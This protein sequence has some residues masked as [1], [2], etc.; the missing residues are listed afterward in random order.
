M[1]PQ[2]TFRRLP[3]FLSHSHTHKPRIISFLFDALALRLIG[4]L[5]SVT[6]YIIKMMEMSLSAGVLR[7]TCVLVAKIES[8]A[9]I[10]R[11]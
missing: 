10:T 6:A 5:E 9:R 3:P 2:A 11:A 1:F 7:L 4:M 8:R